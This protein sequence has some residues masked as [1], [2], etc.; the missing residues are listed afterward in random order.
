VD[1][2]IQPGD[3]GFGL[4]TELQAFKAVG[5]VTLFAAGS[6]LFNPRP[7]N[8][9]QTFRG[10]PSEAVMSVA[11]Q[12]AARAGLSVPVGKVGLSFGA[13]LEGV[14]AEDLIG[15]SEGFRRPGYSIAVEPGV[16]YSWKGNAVS[17]SVPYLVR[18]VRTQSVSDKL[19]SQRLGR[20]V[21]GDAAFADFVVVVGFSRRF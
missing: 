17:L 21:Q 7:T 14:P 9:V 15:S 10:R 1:Q 20:H 6:Y 8:G 5:K 18:R 2:S 16:S 11:D 4:V 13:R 3:G 19:E 12:Y